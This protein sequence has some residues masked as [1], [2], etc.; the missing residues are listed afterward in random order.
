ML[1]PG[2]RVKLGSQLVLNYPLEIDIPDF[3]R[4]ANARGIAPRS[5]QYQTIKALEESR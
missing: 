3:A 4:L 2:V 5:I 1:I